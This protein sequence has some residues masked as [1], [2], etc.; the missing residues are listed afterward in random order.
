VAEAVTETL[1]IARMGHRGDGIADTPEG[2][3]FVPYTL[4]GETVQVERTADRG[5]VL[6]ILAPSTERIDAICL[7]YGTCG[8]C[9]VQHWDFARYRQWKRQTVETALANAGVQ[10]PVGDLVDAHGSGRRRATLHARRGGRK[11]LSVGFAGRRSHAV[12]PIDR[13][14]IVDP[15][16]ER[17]FAIA[18]RLAEALEV[19][20]KPLDIQFTKTMGG[21]DVDVRGSG[22][23]EPVTIARLGQIAAEEKLA[24]L[25]RHGE[26][27]AQLAEPAIMIGRARVALPPGAFL[28]AT[29]AGEAA[30]AAS[31]LKA[32]E[33]AKRVADLFS[34][35]GT[36][37]LRL[38][39]NA[40]VTAFDA[41]EKAIAALAR[42]AAMTQGLK[43]IGAEA[44]DLFRRPLL[45]FELDPFDVI[46]L[47]PP[48]QGAEAQMRTLS[49]SKVRRVIYVSCDAATFARD[50]KLLAA[51]GYRLQ[52]VVPVDQFRYSDHVEL[53]GTFAR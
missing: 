9:A 1:T 22:P 42:A 45:T 27:I 23:P 34:G 12:V 25:T 6:K 16:L 36:F 52:E 48:R 51:G 28:Q 32:A 43:K 33:G 49:S 31:V 15:A 19:S 14:P 18:W 39:E 3:V 26:L 2:P 24:R 4:P 5:R 53:V 20:S 41:D 37:A 35:V 29:E 10:A 30:L 8:G 50:A 11:I 17:A 46:V 40:P 21:L 47:D 7:H 44:R 38:A 13:C